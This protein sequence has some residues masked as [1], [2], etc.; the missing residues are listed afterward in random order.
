MDCNSLSDT[1]TDD[2]ATTNNKIKEPLL[3]MILCRYAAVG[4]GYSDSMLAKDPGW[5][6]L[7]KSRWF[8][9]YVKIDNEAVIPLIHGNLM[10]A[11]KF[12][13]SVRNMSYCMHR[14]SGTVMARRGT[15]LHPPSGSPWCFV[16]SVICNEEAMM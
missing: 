16:H 9:L 3:P 12:G 15:F 4:S 6:S 8:I 7:L 13:F 10:E 5:Q 1:A 14:C 11:S 2:Y